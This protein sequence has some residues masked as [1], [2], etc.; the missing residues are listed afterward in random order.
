M[1]IRHVSGNG[2][3]VTP[4]ELYLYLLLSF[5]AKWLLRVSLCGS[6]VQTR[7][8]RVRSESAVR[9]IGTERCR[10]GRAFGKSCRIDLIVLRISERLLRVM[11]EFE[12]AANL[13]RDPHGIVCYVCLRQSK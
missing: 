3:F 4:A 11:T 8:P 5:I 12:A 6:G 2:N 13:S 9:P 1:E 7:H 10:T